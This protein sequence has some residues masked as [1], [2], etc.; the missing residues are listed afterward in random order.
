MAKNII[1]WEMYHQ[2]CCLMKLIHETNN[3]LKYNQSNQYVYIYIYIYIYTYTYT[4]T[5][6]QKIWT[7]SFLCF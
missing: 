4:H 5:T 7:V 1:N 2:K 6:S 3:I